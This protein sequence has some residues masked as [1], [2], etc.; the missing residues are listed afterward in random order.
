MGA[1]S[2]TFSG[3]TPH[4]FAT[5]SVPGLEARMEAIRQRIQPKFQ[6]LGSTMSAFASELSG[7]P[8]YLHIAKHAR[9]KTNAPID[10]WLAIGPNKRGYKQ[11]PHFQIGLFDD[12]LF[13]WLA[14]IYEL[15]NKVHIAD[16]LLA[17]LE[18]LERTLPS[19][20]VTS[21]DHQK[22]DA[23]TREALGK[24][25]LKEQLIRFRNVKKAEWLI[26]QHIKAEDPLLQEGDLLEAFAKQTFEVLMP[27]YQLV[28]RRTFFSR[29]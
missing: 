10:T 20:Y 9:R 22:K 28:G 26:G 2:I 6:A 18:M 4:D 21:G 14:F 5:F 13:I 24:Q 29:E 7:H 16:T 8:M 17:N 11:L 27:V 12:H 19:Q 3:F 25:G 15:P 23:L 1:N